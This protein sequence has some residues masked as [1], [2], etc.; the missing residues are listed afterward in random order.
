M[1]SKLRHPV[2]AIREPFGT[3]GLI[4]A[5]IA[6][7]TALGGTA[8]AAKGALTGKQK[9]EVEK[10][11]KKFAG[12]P[13]AAGATGLTGATGPAGPRGAT[14]AEGDQGIQGEQGEPGEPGEPGQTG[15]TETL[16]QNETETGSWSFGMTNS[17]PFISISFNIPLLNELD[18]SHVHYVKNAETTT[19]CPGNAKVPSAEPGNFC[20][21]ERTI[22]GGGNFEGAFIWAPGKFPAV[23]GGGDLEGAGTNGAEM[24]LSLSAPS[25]AFGWGSWAV[26]AP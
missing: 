1:K 24:L 23:V 22:Q 26:T 2:R 12:K 25:S 18:A 16:P 7:V 9:K 19:P 15:F 4:V 11:A 3:A 13:G 20:I 10:I 5:M 17:L 14:G 6:L 21:Y 8:L